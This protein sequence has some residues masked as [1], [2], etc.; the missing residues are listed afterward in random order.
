MERVVS[1]NAATGIKIEVQKKDILT[2][3]EAFAE[4]DPALLLECMLDMEAG[5]RY[6]VK[7]LPDAARYALLRQI[8]DH[9]EEVALC[10][11]AERS[12]A[13]HPLS[14]VVIPFEWYEVDDAS[15]GIRY[16]LG[17]ALLREGDASY[18]RKA[19]SC[20]GGYAYELDEVHA[21]EGMLPDMATL[22]PWAWSGLRASSYVFAAEPWQ[23]I[24]KTPIWL[25]SELSPKER[26]FVLAFML[27]MMTAWENGMPTDA[28]PLQEGEV[29]AGSEARAWGGCCPAVGSD[30]AVSEDQL[31]VARSS[32]VGS[33]ACSSSEASYA[34][35]LDNIVKLLNY[36]C[37][38]DALEA[39]VALERQGA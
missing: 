34:Q 33:S 10:A 16:R 5:P 23:S 30:E 29:Q 20:T 8:A 4:C 32:D 15:G 35:R 12:A 36:N 21:A 14:G 26:H 19:L 2:V 22:T 9:L 31:F 17:A 38:V 27:W 13:L 1:M 25:P 37:W 24:A 39:C 18:A 28:K 3:G 11:A 7:A 6:A